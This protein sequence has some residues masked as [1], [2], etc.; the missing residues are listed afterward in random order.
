MLK[1]GGDMVKMESV[2]IKVPVE[3]KKYMLIQ[4]QKQTLSGMLFFFILIY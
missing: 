3:M 4:M 1:R 2:T